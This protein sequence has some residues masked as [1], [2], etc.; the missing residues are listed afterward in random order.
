M[1][2]KITSAFI[3]GFLWGFIFSGVFLKVVWCGF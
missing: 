3:Q 2:E 1:K